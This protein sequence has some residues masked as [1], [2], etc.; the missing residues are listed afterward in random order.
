MTPPRQPK[1][2][3]RKPPQRK[4]PV[5]ATTGKFTLARYD[6]NNWVLTHG[7]NTRYYYSLEAA[8]RRILDLG[9]GDRFDGELRS[10][11]VGME[12]SRDEAVS[13]VRM[14]AEAQS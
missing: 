10:L 8:V 4:Q 2:H 6:D 1:K 13:L 11:L 7:G 12:R 5:T 9:V 3:D 14:I